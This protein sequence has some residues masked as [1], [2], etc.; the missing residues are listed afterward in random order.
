M[1]VKHKMQIKTLRQ[2]H[3]DNEYCKVIFKNFKGM[4]TE[5]ADVVHENNTGMIVRFI[6]MDEKSKVRLIGL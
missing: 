2:N 4:A 5:L 1:D 6:S 3:V